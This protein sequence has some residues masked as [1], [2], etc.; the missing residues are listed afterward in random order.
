MYNK[1]IPVETGN[2]GDFIKSKFITGGCFKTKNVESFISY[3]LKYY[4]NN[5]EFIFYSVCNTTIPPVAMKRQGDI[6]DIYLRKKDV[7]KI[8]RNKNNNKIREHII[9]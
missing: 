1:Y 7:I 4:R 6:L 8:Y 2:K 3:F 9:R 5:R